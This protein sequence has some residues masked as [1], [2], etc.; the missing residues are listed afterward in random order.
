MTQEQIKRFG[1]GVILG[2]VLIVA[3]GLFFLDNLNVLHLEFSL[4]KLWPV[5]LI[6]VGLVKLLE[7]A[8]VRKPIL[9]LFLMAIGTLFLFDQLGYI[10]FDF[11][12]LWP[13]LIIFAGVSIVKQHVYGGCR[14]EG[15][16]KGLGSGESRFLCGTKNKDYGEDHLNFSAIMGGGGYRVSSRHLKGGRILAIMGGFELNLR[17]ADMDGNELHIDITTIMGGVEI[18]VPTTWTVILQ[19]TPLMGGFENRT[20]P[21]GESK[22]KL[23]VHA[24]VIMGGIEFKN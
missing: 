23:I 18:T 1:P 8:P 17:D 9:G 21:Q 13:L 11:A 12:Y 22:K 6:A 7:P 15:E 14:S 2:L 24:S 16:D 5:I 10:E 20:S 4:W 19:G 3:G